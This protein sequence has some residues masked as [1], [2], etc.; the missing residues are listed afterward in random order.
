MKRPA[1][2][3]TCEAFTLDRAS[4]ARWP[5]AMLSG[6][7]VIWA[8]G[9]ALAGDAVETLWCAT[10][11][12]GFGLAAIA[13]GPRWA[14]GGG[15]ALATLGPTRWLADATVAEDWTSS[16]FALG[17]GTNAAA[18]VLLGQLFHLWNTSFPARLAFGIVALAGALMLLQEGPFLSWAL[19][20]LLV[21]AGATGLA[22]RPPA[23]QAPREGPEI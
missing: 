21:L 8:M 14:I 13:R 3:A 19:P 18:V 2:D 22:A 12:L 11:A 1:L 4:H 6:A 5:F 23:W 9:S 20:G 17:I 16:W 7:G 15:L 10:V